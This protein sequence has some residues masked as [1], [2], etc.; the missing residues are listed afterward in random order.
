M[1]V[2]G[3][4]S[5]TITPTV[6]NPQNTT[7]MMKKN[8]IPALLLLAALCAACSSDNVVAEVPQPSEPETV[9]TLRTTGIPV[10]TAR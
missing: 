10:V 2:N 6:T 4:L 9:T 5:G 7:D 8:I 3:T 1:E